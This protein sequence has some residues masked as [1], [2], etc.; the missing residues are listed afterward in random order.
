MIVLLGSC[1]I[2]FPQFNFSLHILI[3][4][5][6]VSLLKEKALFEKESS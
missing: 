4:L 6:E 1:L 3:S 2:L 5:S